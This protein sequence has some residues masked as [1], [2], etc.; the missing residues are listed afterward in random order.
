MWT[1]TEKPY[2]RR[3]WMETT[4]TTARPMVNTNYKSYQG[5]M[6]VSYY[7]L[8][9]LLCLGF[10]MLLEFIV[11]VVV[12]MR[13]E[14]LIFRVIIFGSL[15]YWMCLFVVVVCGLPRYFF[16]SIKG[17]GF[18]KDIVDFFIC[19]IDYVFGSCLVLH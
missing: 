1:W 2:Q 10:F 14:F 11:S 15:C 16:G 18:V 12:F 7:S 5:K 6:K 4:G 9:C 13:L 19:C 17:H 8:F 3:R